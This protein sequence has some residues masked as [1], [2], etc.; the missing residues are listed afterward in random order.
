[1]PSE[2]IIYNLAEQNLTSTC[3]DYS[4]SAVA[5]LTILNYGKPVIHD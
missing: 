5:A 2:R 4:P 1:M 3:P